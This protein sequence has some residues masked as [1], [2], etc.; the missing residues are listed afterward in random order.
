[1]QQTMRTM[2][3]DLENYEVK[4][5]V[6]Q[7]GYAKASESFKS[8]LRIMFPAAEYRHGGRGWEEGVLDAV[9][10]ETKETCI[11]Q[12]PADRRINLGDLAVRDVLGDELDQMGK[13]LHETL[14]LDIT[15]LLKADNRKKVN[16]HDLFF[17]GF[18]NHHN[19]E[20][21]FATDCGTLFDDNCLGLLVKKILRKK[22]C[23]AVTGRQRVMSREMQPDCGSE[24]CMGWMLR[25]VQGYDYESSVVLFNGCFSKLGFL[26]VIPGPC[27]LFRLPP[28]LEV[29][30]IKGERKSPMDFY[31]DA[32]E[33][34]E[35]SKTMLHG[36]CMLA[37]DR[38][39]TFAAEFLTTGEKRVHW[40]KNA[41]FYFQA[42][43]ELRRLV[44]QRRR[45]LNGT[46]AAYF[47]VHNELAD[48]RL[49]SSHPRWKV[50][51]LRTLIKLMLAIYAGIAVGPS[52]YAYGIC[53]A[54]QYLWTCQP[55]LA[56]D[57]T[58][59][60]T[61]QTS[62][63]AIFQA[64]LFGIAALYFLSF[65]LFSVRHHRSAF[66][67]RLFALCGF[68]NAV[69]MAIMMWALVLSTIE[70]L[71]VVQ[72]FGFVYLVV[73]ILLNLFIPNFESLKHLLHPLRVVVFFLF[74]PTMQ[75]NFLTL[76]IARTFDLSWGNR[77]G[78]GGKED[79]LKNQT[80]SYMIL[81]WLA[82]GV[83][84]VLL[85][86]FDNSAW[87]WFIQLALAIVLLTPTM[88]LSLGSAM[89][90]LGIPFVA[91]GMIMGACLILCRV[92]WVDSV[93]FG[94][95]QIIAPVL[96]TSPIFHMPVLQVT[97]VLLLLIGLKSARRLFR[98]WL[99]RLKKQSLRAGKDDETVVCT[100]KSLRA[101]AKSKEESFD[102]GV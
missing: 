84:L 5:C 50:F 94:G 101:V 37:E 7:D 67:P 35:K 70:G 55:N 23:V 62:P 12:V 83:L 10:A 30:T 60:N 15:V 46:I 22:D 57:S 93:L 21:V 9:A 77:D 1:M 48:K 102:L 53:E 6:I 14:P 79:C 16:S 91:L 98:N 99:K 38:V 11:L 95:D 87:L 18:A 24:G 100:T 36:N 47:Y 41:I 96:T 45:W 33:E 74:M 32:A 49:P 20:F 27:G 65:V 40:C 44:G 86:S 52:L 42:E 28:L 73:P 8:A 25:C 63:P 58:D 68:L 71:S 78:I 17:R 2:H 3:K 81:Q 75:G 80:Y 66:D 39:L 56:L 90:L 34:A 29:V 89:Q 64:V 97:G 51:L 82:N 69:A 72:W 61:V 59:S 31:L 54:L 13:D 19:P 4:V 76:A 26:P 88:L 92:G 43:T 85:F